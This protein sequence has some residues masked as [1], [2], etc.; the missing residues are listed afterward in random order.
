M[1]ENILASYFS[2]DITD[3]P[4]VCAAVHDG[5][6]AVALAPADET[7]LIARFPQLAPLSRCTLTAEGWMDQET[8]EPALVHTLH[9]FTCQSDSRCTGWA[10]YNVQGAASPSQLYTAVWQ[11]D[12]W[13]FT[14]DP[15]IIAQ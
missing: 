4:T 12:A 13:Q 9:S 10:S 15:Q 3:P 8:E 1:M 5:R 7:A 6:E 11:G 2:A 14:S